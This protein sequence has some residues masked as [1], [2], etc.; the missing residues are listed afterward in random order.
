MAVSDT[1]LDS[2]RA[3]YKELGELVRTLRRKLGWT[4][5]Q[6]AVQAGVPYATVF[7]IQ[8]G[9]PATPEDLAKIA[10]ALRRHLD[11]DA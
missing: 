10:K 5:H 6:L 7:E 9:N 4:G 1:D 8:R 11:G 3:L 2:L